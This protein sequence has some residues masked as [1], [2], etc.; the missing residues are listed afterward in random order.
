V[1]HPVSDQVN[2]V[3]ND[4]PELIVAADHSDTST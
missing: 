4:H 3:R 1:W 2:N